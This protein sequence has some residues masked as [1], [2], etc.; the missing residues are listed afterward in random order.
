MIVQLQL[1][2][3]TTFKH[4][5]I[6]FSPKINVIIGENGTGKTHILKAAYGLSMASASPDINASD[7]STYLVRLFRPLGNRI[8]RL[9]HSEG[10]TNISADFHT[11]AAVRAS[12][13]SSK[14]SMEFANSATGQVNPPLLIPAKEIMSVLSQISKK[15]LTAD[16]FESLFDISYI[17]LCSA[18]LGDDDSVDY[19]TD[20]R[21]GTIIP[22]MAKKIGGRYEFAKKMVSFQQ[23]QYVEKKISPSKSKYA[24]IYSDSTKIIFEP[25]SKEGISNSMTAEGFRKIGTIQR[26]LEN[27]YLMHS[28]DAPLFWDEPE[29]N[30]NPKLMELLVQT[31]LDLSRNGKQII[32][33]SHDYF[34]LKWLDLL[35]DKENKEDHVRFHALHRDAETGEIRV[36]HTDNYLDI[37]KNSIADTFSSITNFEISQSMGG[38]GR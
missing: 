21:L 38:L 8:G 18:L 29:A 37:N 14:S 2:N 7:F 27:G 33:A 25:S 35:A 30:M 31:L 5:E 34:L 32:I 1:E 3:F 22:N 4:I 13:G 15:D 6:D 9:R 16:W 12:F 19:R 20:Q 26:L 23:G 28:I 10:K 36:E 11:G 17:D 24:E